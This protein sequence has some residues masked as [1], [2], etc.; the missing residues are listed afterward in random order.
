MNGEKI[1]IGDLEAE[2]NAE[3]CDGI[4][5]CVI[6]HGPEGRAVAKAAVPGARAVLTNSSGEEF[7]GRVSVTD[8]W[9][10]VTAVDIETEF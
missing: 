5:T 1:R 2:M 8:P 4:V 7:E 6:R 3:P 9:G 10:L